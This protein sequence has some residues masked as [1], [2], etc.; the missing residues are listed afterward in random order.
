[1]CKKPQTKQLQTKPLSTSQFLSTTQHHYAAL[2]ARQLKMQIWAVRTNQAAY[3]TT[4]WKPSKKHQ[5]TPYRVKWGPMV[6]QSNGSTMKTF[7]WLY[8]RGS[9]ASGNRKNSMNGSKAD[10]I[11]AILTMMTIHLRMLL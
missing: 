5:T 10:I 1:M 7:R 11:T 8:M 4:Q 9:A 2:W 3:A 6:V